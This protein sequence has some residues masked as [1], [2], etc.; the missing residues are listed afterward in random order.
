MNLSS[1]LELIHWSKELYSELPWRKSRTL[2]TT[3]V[4]EIMLQQTTVGTVKNHFERFI[5]TYPEIKKLA[6]ST[7]EELLIAW[8][9]LGYYRRAK[10]LKSIAML[11]WENYAGQFPADYA[12]LIALKGVGPY[13]ANAILAIGM[14][15]KALALDANL[16]R[17]LAR[18]FGYQELKGTKLQNKIQEEFSKKNIFPFTEQEISFRELNE[19]L[20]DLGRVLCTAQKTLCLQCPLKKNCYAHLKKMTRSL[21]MIK[22]KENSVL[23]SIDKHTL[24]ILRFYIPTSHGAIAYQK[25][26]GEWLEKQFERPS[27]VVEVSDEKFKQYPPLGEKFK[28]KWSAILDGKKPFKSSIT[29]YKIENYILEMSLVDFR[30]F[31]KSWSKEQTSF[32]VEYKKLEER[33]VELK[34]NDFIKLSSVHQKFIPLTFHCSSETESVNKKP[35]EGVGRVLF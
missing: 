17:V 18:F 25:I 7:E 2:Y 29:K 14:N 5:D 15:K 19:A 23:K 11:L 35:R 3:L 26:K 30:K 31:L 34:K 6:L 27:F 32:H 9:G 10:S 8:K 22:A 24:K 16:E 1:S 13:T 28:K 21:P 4:S 33:F 20:M 12:S